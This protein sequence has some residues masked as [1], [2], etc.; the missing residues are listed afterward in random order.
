MEQ[1]RRHRR[2]GRRSGELDAHRRATKQC[3]VAKEF[4]TDPVVGRHRERANEQERRPFERNVDECDAEKREERGRG[5][6]REW[7]CRAPGAID[8]SSE[9]ASELGGD[10]LSIRD[11]R[12]NVK[13]RTFG[14]V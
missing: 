9:R 1:L 2:G 8:D 11:A 4:K 13:E 12:E 3:D 10:L 14:F 7:I 5:E 6:V